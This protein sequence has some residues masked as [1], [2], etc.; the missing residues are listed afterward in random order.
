MAG[1][2]L[3]NR[4]GWYLVGRN[5]GLQATKPLKK[6]HVLDKLINKLSGDADLK[7]TRLL[8]ITLVSFGLALII[9]LVIVWLHDEKSAS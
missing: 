2:S 6:H 9:M 3:L 1:L 4:H 7:W 8:L 5:H